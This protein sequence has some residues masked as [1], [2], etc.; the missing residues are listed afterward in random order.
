MRSSAPRTFFSQSRSSGVVKRSAFASVW[1]RSYSAGTRA[2]FAFET[3]MKYPNTPLKRMRRLFMPLRLRSLAS[4]AA[5][6]CLAL[7][8]VE[9]NSSSSAE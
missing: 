9:R 4:S 8:L 1:R 2:A 6:I 7:R 5:M 3:S